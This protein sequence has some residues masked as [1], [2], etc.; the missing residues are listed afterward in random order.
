MGESAAKTPQ[1]LGSGEFRINERVATNLVAQGAPKDI[2][3]VL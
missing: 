1:Q 3:D 2:L